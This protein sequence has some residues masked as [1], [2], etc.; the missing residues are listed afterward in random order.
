MAMMRN[1]SLVENREN[2]LFNNVLNKFCNFKIKV[3]LEQKK[4]L[5]LNLSLLFFL[6]IK[7]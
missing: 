7:K 1:K 6:M 3:T 4:K 2:K 5:I